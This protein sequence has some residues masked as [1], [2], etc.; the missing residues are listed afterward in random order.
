MKLLLL[1][2][3]LLAGR[4][5][6][7]RRILLR[8]TLLRPLCRKLLFLRHRWRGLNGGKKMSWMGGIDGKLVYRC[9][10]LLQTGIDVALFNP[11]SWSWSL[12]EHEVIST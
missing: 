1:R 8:D 9:L 3:R 12:E 5:I 10:F 6:L 11:V 7:R 4:M 2:L